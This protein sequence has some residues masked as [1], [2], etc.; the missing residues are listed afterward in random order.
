FKL[1]LDEE[2]GWNLPRVIGVLV[3]VAQAMAFAHVNGVIHRD[4]KPSNIMVGEFGAVYVMDWGLARMKGRSD[5]HDIRP[6]DPTRLTQLPV[7][8]GGVPAAHSPLITMDGAV[9]GTPAYMPPE[10]ALGRASAVDEQSDVYALGAILYR[11][12]AGHPPYA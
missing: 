3:K 12:L 4:L 1:A 5:L 11:L 9:I 7:T 2:E 8:P 10:Q 6:Q